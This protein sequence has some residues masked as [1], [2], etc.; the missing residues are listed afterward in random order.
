MKSTDLLQALRNADEKFILETEERVAE[1]MQPKRRYWKPFLIGAAGI[2]ACF[3]I[4]FFMLHGKSNDREL[5]TV[6]NDPSEQIEEATLPVSSQTEIAY[7]LTSTGITQ[8]TTPDGSEIQTILFTTTADPEAPQQ[9][10]GSAPDT[11]TGI[12]G[13]LVS[14]STSAKTTAGTESGSSQ[15]VI[16]FAHI[17]EVNGSELIVRPDIGAFELSSSKRFS[18]AASNLP[19]GTIPTVGMWL[20]IHYDG[21]IQEVSPARFN[22]ITKITVLEELTEPITDQV[23][24]GKNEVFVWHDLIEEQLRPTD[25]IG[26]TGSYRLF[27]AAMPDTEIIWKH[28]GIYLKKNNTE[29]LI[30]GSGSM[31]HSNTITPWQVYFTDLSGDGCPE[32]IVG[33]TTGVDYYCSQRVMVYDF[34]TQ[35]SEWLAGR[36]SYDVVLRYRD[37]KMYVEEIPWSEH[38]VLDF[39]NMSG[40]LATIEPDIEKNSGNYS[41]NFLPL[42]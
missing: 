17:T 31:Q 24:I 13:D 38:P 5:L 11:V 7:E 32:M 40:L 42:D 6:A 2:A 19:A 26:D 34:R 18:V 28:Y 29:T 23:Q 8:F 14:Y 37:G 35:E 9:S 15:D 41:L 10:Q 30:F 25:T 27:L 16:C 1:A 22:R 4:V 36:K 33:F 20:E 39:K 3:G 12:T 21:M